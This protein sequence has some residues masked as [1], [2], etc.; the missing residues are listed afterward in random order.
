ME[1]SRDR[2]REKGVKS[3]QAI[4]NAAIECIAHCG[5]CDTTLDRVAETAKVSR[6]LVV[7]HFKSKKGMMT[8]VL[9]EITAQ[10]MDDW[11]RLFSE[12]GI[13]AKERLKNLIVYDVSL[14]IEKPEL[15]AVF[16][17]FWGEAKGLY[18]ELGYTRDERYEM[19]LKTLI[20]EI[21]KE[22]RYKTVDP[23]MVT[24]ALVTMLFGFWLK[25]HLDLSS[26][27]FKYSMAV[28]ESYLSKVFP[29]H[30]R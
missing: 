5:L 23:E 4:T 28:I 17:T 24:S 29:K 26:T 12:Q 1:P 22:G 20:T 8:A 21:I 11:D 30:Y 2:R 16:H 15:I 10:Y 19:D 18:K 25:A 9:E 6:A 14:P 13:P 27:H 7:F 3:R